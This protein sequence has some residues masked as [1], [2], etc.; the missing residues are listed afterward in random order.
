MMDITSEGPVPIV[1]GRRLRSWRPTP[2]FEIINVCDAIHNGATEV[3]GGDPNQE[4]QKP[5]KP[6]DE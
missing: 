1:E 3:V 4:E 6:R 2:R 5:E